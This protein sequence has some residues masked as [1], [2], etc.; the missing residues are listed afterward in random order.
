MTDDLNQIKVIQ[1]PDFLLDTCILQ[2]IDSPYASIGVSKLLDFLLRTGKV[3]RISYYAVFEL[4]RGA[5]KGKEQK[6]EETLKRFVKYV[7]NDKVFD[8]AAKLYTLYQ[9]ENKQ[10]GGMGGISD[11]DII[12]AATSIIL[13]QPI[14]TRDGDDFPA[15]FFKEI[16]RE[17]ITYI[18]K[19]K[20]ERS[21]VIYFLA[22]DKQVLRL[23]L[24]ELNNK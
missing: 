5:D 2:D 14:I 12:L 6:A 23:K 3:L 18:P 19:G 4:L 17:I 22:P 7:V 8:F 15:P 11:G 9:K 20:R 10:I 21:L 1:C 13:N 24:L 16:H